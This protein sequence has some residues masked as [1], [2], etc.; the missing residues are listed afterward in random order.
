MKK[1]ITPIN[2]KANADIGETI[3]ETL[4]VGFLPSFLS[5]VVCYVLSALFSTILI[6]LLYLL[7][8]SLEKALNTMT[9][10][11]GT[12]LA[13]LFTEIIA[14]FSLYLAILLLAPFAENRQKSFTDLSKGNK[15]SLRRGIL[16][17]IEA[18]WQSEILTALLITLVSVFALPPLIGFGPFSFFTRT[19]GLT[20]STIIAYLFSLIFKLF[21]VP[22]AQKKWRINFYLEYA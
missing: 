1:L 5:L 11:D 18:H 6:P 4:F 2:R 15:V 17:H 7:I 10:E 13:L 12:A 20:G 19:L 22:Y 14:F 16:H 8:P 9:E 3:K 21:T